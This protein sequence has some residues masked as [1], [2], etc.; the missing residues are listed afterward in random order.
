[1]NDLKE[2]QT[3]WFYRMDDHGETPLSRA[4]QSGYQAL[5]DLLLNHERTHAADAEDSGSSSKLH[6]AAYWGLSG[7]VR[8]LLAAG[9]DPGEEDELGDTPLMKAARNGHSAA[10]EALIKHGAAIDARNGDGMTTLHWVALNGRGDIAELLL[11]HGAEVNAREKT[12]SGLTPAG[13][14]LLMGYYDL[15]DLFSSHG[16]RF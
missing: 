10:V 15:V 1:V 5:A 13:M 6:M 8:K 16:G 14:A 9:A 12:T 7:A 4:K 3:P 11:E 2:T